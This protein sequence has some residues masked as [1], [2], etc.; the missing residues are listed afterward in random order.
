MGKKNRSK[1][2]PSNDGIPQFGLWTMEREFA[3]LD[4]LMAGQ[5]FASMEDAEAFVAQILADN[6]GQ[7]PRQEPETDLERAQALIYDAF[8]STGPKRAE[9]ALKALE[10]SADCAD[11]Y[12]LLAEESTATLE[13]MLERYEQAVAAGERVLGA[14]RLAN[15]FDPFW[16]SVETRP[17]MRALLG[18]ASTLWELGR[19]DE[20][21]R[22]FENLLRLNPND[23]QGVRWT[24]V[25]AYLT[26]GDYRSAGDL[27]KCYEYDSS[28]TW[29]YSRLLWAFHQ[30]GP[31]PMASEYLENALVTNPHVVGYL[32][33]HKR[34][35][36]DASPSYSPGSEEEALWY[37]FEGGL[38]WLACPAALEWLVFSLISA[39][40]QR[41]PITARPR[42][43]L[44]SGIED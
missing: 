35:S 30:Y 44:S 10:I 19:R 21:I 13:E 28:A 23:N 6:G 24:L 27:L 38:A 20:A 4:K 15:G 32:L 33:G 43:P 3:S 22:H 26:V 29:A 37:L 2:K 7:V 8:T 39:G 9:L 17:Y 42:R 11:A 31:G 40:E 36:T 34:V 12:V 25:S 5:H 16:I 1:G 18:L 14:E 41:L